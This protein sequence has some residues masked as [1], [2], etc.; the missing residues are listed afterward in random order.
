MLA[1]AG[2]EAT[3]RITGALAGFLR[4]DKLKTVHFAAGRNPPPLT[5]F[6]VHFPRLSVTLEGTD[7]MEVEHA[8]TP[9]RLSLKR[10]DAVFVPANCWNKPTW[11]RR[12]TVLHLL[13]GQKHLGVSLVEHDGLSEK[14]ARVYK[15]GMPRA[16]SEPL[17]EILAAIHVLTGHSH[18]S[19]VAQSLV[20][21]LLET[22]LGLLERAPAGQGRK[23]RNTYER[24]CLYVQEH[25]HQRLTR[26]SVARQFR[27]NPNHLSRLFRKEGLVR[28]TDY[29]TQ[30]RVARAK[31]L[32]RHFDLG[33][34]ELAA[35]CG[36]HNAAY[37]CRVFKQRVHQT[38]TGYRLAART[39]SEPTPRHASPGKNREAI[40]Q[41]TLSGG[42]GRA[43]GLGRAPTGKTPADL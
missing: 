13:F 19:L 3:A 5:A 4:Q 23:G 31:Y 16:G 22:V 2:S 38:P 15:S 41:K 17:G 6:A 11:A 40:R 1:D 42:K 43:A 33:L 39:G 14:P 12:A 30:T 27:L 8:G 36:F 35:N 18:R 34:D 9:R 28:F 21:A 20:V 37:F 10:G 24:A 25:F 7:E 32:L 29:L 26:G